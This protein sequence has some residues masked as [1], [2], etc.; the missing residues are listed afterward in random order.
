M[1]QERIVSSIKRLNQYKQRIQRGAVSRSEKPGDDPKIENGKLS[2]QYGR[3][4]DHDK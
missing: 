4:E 2:S 3:R 1:N